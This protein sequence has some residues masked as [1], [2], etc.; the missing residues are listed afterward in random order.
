MVFCKQVS[1]LAIILFTELVVVCALFKMIYWKFLR[2]EELVSLEQYISMAVPTSI[3]FKITFKH[4]YF[5]V[6]SGSVKNYLYI[7][8]KSNDSLL[9]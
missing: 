8:E 3:N 6:T 2:S 4:K 5:S 1:K 7:K 9:L